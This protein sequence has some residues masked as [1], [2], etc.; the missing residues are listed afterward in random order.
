[1]HSATPDK[2][3]DVRKLAARRAYLQSLLMLDRILGAGQGSY[4]SIGETESAK[5]R[6]PFW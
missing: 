5:M 3:Y 2:L 6:S 1:V 4:R